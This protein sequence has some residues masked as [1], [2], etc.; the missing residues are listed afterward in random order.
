M[1]VKARAAAIATDADAV[2]AAEE[3]LAAKGSAVD[4]VVAGFFSLAGRSPAVL[5]APAVALLF[6]AGAGARAFDGRAVQPGAGAAR[7]RGHLPD[8]APPLQARVAAPRAPHMVVLMHASQ[9]RR[10]LR[11]AAKRGAAEAKR[12]GASRRAELIGQIGEGAI[13]PLLRTETLRAQLRIAGANVGGQLTEDDLA[14][15]SSTDEPAR[16]AKADNDVSVI[17]EPWPSAGAGPVAAIAAVDAWGLAAAIASFAGDQSRGV[18]VPELEVTLPA[19][20]EPVRRGHTRV[21]PHT[22]LPVPARIALV[23]AG[24][25]LRAAVIFE[26]ERA[27]KGPLLRPTIAAGLAGWGAA[28]AALSESGQARPWRAT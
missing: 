6:G 3:I 8:E 18:L 19:V 1:A 14:E 26:G 16:V 15:P 23:D 22:A 27:G 25:A 10:P 20:A 21:A 17:Q 2:A 7:P 12:A 24:A 5:F 4:A 9:G 13:Q 28:L 11:E